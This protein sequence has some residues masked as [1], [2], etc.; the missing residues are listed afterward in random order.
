[1]LTKFMGRSG[2]Y[3]KA[4]LVLVLILSGPS[5]FASGTSAPPLLRNPSGTFNALRKTMENPGLS[6]D[7]CM[8]AIRNLNGAV[9]HASIGLLKNQLR[10]GSVR[11]DAD[12]EQAPDNASSN[13]FQAL[14]HFKDRMYQYYLRGEIKDEDWQEILLADRLMRLADEEIQ[15]F[16]KEIL[17]YISKGRLPAK[18]QSRRLLSRF[19]TPYYDNQIRLNP[20]YEKDFYGPN[21]LPIGANLDEMGV[22]FEKLKDG[23]KSGDVVVTRAKAKSGISP[24]ISRIANSIY[25]DSDVSHVFVVYKFTDAQ[26]IE[27]TKYIEAMIEDGV[28]VQ[29]WHHFAEKVEDHRLARFA[30]MRFRDPEVAA[31]GAERLYQLV[32]EMKINYDFKYQR[33]A[34]VLGEVDFTKGWDEVKKQLVAENRPKDLFCSAISEFMIYL[35]SDGKVSV[36]SHPTNI[37]M[38]ND[39]FLK[40]FGM[41]RGPVSAPADFLRDPRFDY[42]AWVRDP[43][44]AHGANQADSVSDVI[45]EYVENGYR[46]YRDWKGHALVN[47]LYPL[48]NIRPDGHPIWKLRFFKFLQKQFPQ[49][50]TEETL[51]FMA[52]MQNVYERLFQALKTAERAYIRKNGQQMTPE[53]RRQFVRDYIEADKTAAWKPIHLI[54]RPLRYYFRVGSRP[55]EYQAQK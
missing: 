3:L 52:S 43:I 11:P 18:E 2:D 21:G 4:F 12:P 40:Q 46:F 32:S 51:A 39:W 31:R 17:P 16:Q 55:M 53:Q 14:M 20:K 50:V 15:Y 42:V 9:R 13:L 26:G 25:E 5:T 41:E 28:S 37:E 30:V 7:N 24:A 49:N 8:I 38:K 36:P 6:Y 27:Q 19:A 34:K 47:V 23:L 1:L 35:G 10:P 44:L 45:Y 33:L 54:R 22:D 48:R 29:D